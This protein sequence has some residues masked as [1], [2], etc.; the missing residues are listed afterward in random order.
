[1]KEDDKGPLAKGT[2]LIP[3]AIIINTF[4]DLNWTGET[5]LTEQDLKIIRGGILSTK[6]YERSLL[7]KMTMATFKLIAKNKPE[8]VF[9]FG[10]GMLSK[11]LLK[12]Y[13]GPFD[14]NNPREILAKFASYYGN[15]WLN[16]GKAEFIPLE[17]GG[18]FRINDPEGIPFQECIVPMLK[19][20]FT[21]LIKAN[22]GKN[23]GIECEEESLV[24][25]RKL[26]TLTANI[27]WE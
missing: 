5:E 4:K 19:G 21:G 1:M 6:W 13:S 11:I 9:R 24:H 17:K 27:S 3:L 18:I 2:I 7:E 12:I 22:G 20:V 25:S 14:S 10:E 23:I 15:A 16:S 26:T 8:E